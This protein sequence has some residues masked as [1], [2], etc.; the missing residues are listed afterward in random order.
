M[1]AQNFECRTT[2]SFFIRRAHNGAYAR[3]TFSVLGVFHDGAFAQ[4]RR[5][6]AADDGGVDDLL[7]D[8]GFVLNSR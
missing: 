1:R 6:V 8:R 4:R 7:E 2:D 3:P 5:C